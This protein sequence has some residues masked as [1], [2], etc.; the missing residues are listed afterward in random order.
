MNSISELL[1][2]CRML[3]I[4]VFSVI[5]LIKIVL[6]FKYEKEWNSITFFHFTAT[7]LKMTVSKELRK[8]RR[9]QNNLTLLI[10]L[11]V[12]LLAITSAFNLLI[13]GS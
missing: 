5:F 3:L 13:G 2:I 7:Q 4:L 9:R 6:F 12:L 1:V 11:I 10:I 8:R